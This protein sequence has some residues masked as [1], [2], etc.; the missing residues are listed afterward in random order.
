MKHLLKTCII[1]ASIISILFTSSCSSTMKCSVYGA[2]NSKIYNGDGKYLGTISSNGKCDVK[3]SRYKRYDFLLT[4]EAPDTPLIPMGLD[5]KARHNQFRDFMG[6]LFCIPTIWISGYAWMKYGERADVQDALALR[7]KQYSN[8]NMSQL[9]MSSVNPIDEIRSIEPTAHKSGKSKKASNES[10]EKSKNESMI[11]KTGEITVLKSFS[12]INPM[13]DK[14][15]GKY[16]VTGTIRFI[17]FGQDSKNPVCCV[18]FK[19]K[20][21]NTIYLILKTRFKKKGKDYIAESDENGKVTISFINNKEA[22]ISF[23]KDMGIFKFRF[24]PNSFKKE[25]EKD[26]DEFE[27]FMLD[28]MLQY[29][30]D[31]K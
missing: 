17:D 7:N 6:I 14:E 19:Y 3:L 2:P 30:K 26:D 22:T 1:V 12:I 24:D 11:N 29:L 20:G 5:Y 8:T 21:Q 27:D 28:L 13:N 10:S 4:Q 18:N 31:G 15:V 16:D 23:W 9:V 25:D